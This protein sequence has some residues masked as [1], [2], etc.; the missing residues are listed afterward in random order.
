MVKFAGEKYK[1]FLC[2]V[3]KLWF[4]LFVKKFFFE[5]QTL[6]KITYIVMSKAKFVIS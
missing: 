2:L 6:M 4:S 1:L 5:L 3:S